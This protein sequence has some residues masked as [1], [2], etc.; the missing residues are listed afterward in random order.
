MESS[1]AFSNYFL[2]MKKSTRHFCQV[3][4]FMRYFLVGDARFELVTPAV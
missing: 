3:L 1:S 4:D 2:D